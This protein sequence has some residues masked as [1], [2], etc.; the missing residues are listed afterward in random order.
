MTNQR[1][2]LIKDRKGR[3]AVR[4]TTPSGVEGIVDT[5]IGPEA[6]DKF[7]KSLARKIAATRKK[8]GEDSAAKSKPVSD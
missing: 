8:N 1:A 7:A 4:F 2:K 6:L 5:S 3:E